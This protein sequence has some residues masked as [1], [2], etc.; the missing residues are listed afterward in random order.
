M[1]LLKFGLCIFLYSATSVAEANRSKECE[2][3]VSHIKIGIT[4]TEL[5]QHTQQDGG[6]SGVLK[7][8]RYRSND[9]CKEITND[10]RPYCL[11]L[12]IDVDLIP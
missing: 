2:A 6:I 8:E 9:C 11:S 10:K 3:H 12:K 1:K 5:E 7:G 4:R